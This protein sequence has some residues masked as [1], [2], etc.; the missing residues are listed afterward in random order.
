MGE[1][2]T[3]LVFVASS[4]GNCSLEDANS[5]SRDAGFGRI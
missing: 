1:D 2:S 5:E 3:L 4:V